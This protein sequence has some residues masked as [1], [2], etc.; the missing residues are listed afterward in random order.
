MVFLS[1]VERKDVVVQTIS[2]EPS[3]MRTLGKKFQQV[4]ELAIGIPVNDRNL[5]AKIV[6]IRK[7]PSEFRISGVSIINYRRIFHTIVW[8]RLKINMRGHSRL[9]H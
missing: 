7:I 8:R 9:S 6:L 4:W 1:E 2:R 3:V 5:I